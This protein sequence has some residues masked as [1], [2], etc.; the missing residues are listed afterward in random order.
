MAFVH[1]RTCSFQ[2]AYF[3]EDMRGFNSL[4]ANN[5]FAECNER[6][7]T[8]RLENERCQIAIRIRSRS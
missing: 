7:S 4:N 1:R 2:Y 5:H 3:L 6:I 8:K